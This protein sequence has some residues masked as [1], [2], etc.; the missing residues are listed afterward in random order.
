MTNTDRFIFICAT[1]RRGQFGLWPTYIDLFAKKLHEIVKNLV[2]RGLGA[3]LDPVVINL[4][5]TARNRSL[6]QG[7]TFTG[8]CLSTGGVHGPG[9]AWSGGCMV[10]G[11]VHDP[12]GA[13]SQGVHGPG[14]CMV[15]GGAWSWGVHGPGCM[16][17]GGCMVETPP[18]A[19]AAAGTHPTGMHSCYTVVMENFLL[20]I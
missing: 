2:H 5:I 15:Q 8:V 4:L 16:V 6:G 20:A 19:T 7:N 1:H 9:V 10:L 17:P 3:P 12:G 11:G 18:T 13:W 14:G